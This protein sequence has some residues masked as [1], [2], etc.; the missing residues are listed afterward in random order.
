MAKLAASHP[1]ASTPS[2]SSW[3]KKSFLAPHA[4]EFCD[5]QLLWYLIVCAKHPFEYFFPKQISFSSHEELRSK[6]PSHILKKNLEYW[7]CI[8]NKCM[9]MNTPIKM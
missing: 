6:I 4:E 3:S 7:S 5:I 8:T 1:S 2:S 9:H